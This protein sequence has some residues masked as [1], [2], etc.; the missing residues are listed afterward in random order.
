MLVDAVV[1]YRDDLVQLI[2][3]ELAGANANKPVRVLGENCLLEAG[4]GVPVVDLDGEVLRE[5][6]AV[7]ETIEADELGHGSR[8]MYSWI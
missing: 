4:K 8:Y 6:I 1:Y 3:G 7:D 5:L 2:E